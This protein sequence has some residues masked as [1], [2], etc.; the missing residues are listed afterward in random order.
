MAQF[1]QRGQQIGRDQYNA[2]TMHFGTVSSAGDLVAELE[3]LK[4]VVI[5]A[6]QDGLL[7]KK[8]ETDVEY[9]ITKASQEAEEPK[10]T[11]KTILEYLSTAKSLVDGVTG[12][13]GLV[14]SIVTAIEA[15][16]RL[17]S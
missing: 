2:D 15:V 7:D 5:Q 17:F 3:K 12:A 6:Q 9:Q 4:R 1:D 10:P 14:S 16:H 13:G 8:R 11:K